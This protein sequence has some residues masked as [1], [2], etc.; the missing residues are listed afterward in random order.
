[1]TIRPPSPRGSKLR[2][3]PLL[4]VG[5]LAGCSSDNDAAPAI[6]IADEPVV[7]PND[8]LPGVVI[9]IDAVRG[10]A[11]GRAEVGDRLAIDFTVKTAAGKPLELS[12]M[13]RGAIMVSGPTFNYQRVIASQ[14]DVLVRARKRALGAFTYEFQ[15][16]IP[17][18]YLPPLNDTDAITEGELTGQPLL[19]GTYTIGL[20]LR[21]DYRV[22]LETYRDPGNA[23]I[24][25]LLGGATTLE[26]REVVTLANCNQCHT[27]LRAHGD[28]RDRITNCLLCHTSGAEDRNTP[29]VAGG[30]PGV[31]I[32]FKV[33]IHKIHAGR[34]LPSVLGVTTNPNGTRKYDAPKRPYQLIGYNDSVADFSTVSFPAW[35]S[36]YTGMPRDQGHTLL[37]PAQQSLEN[38]MRAAPV[39]CA[40]CHG[41]PDGDGALPAPAQSELIW[42]QPTIAACASCH[43]DWVPDHLYTANGQTMPIQR[44]NAACKDC[45]RVSGT[46]LDVVDA[47]RHPLVDPSVVQGVVFDVTSVVDRA[48]NGATNGKFEPGDE[49]EIVF[50]VKNNAGTPIAASALSR[51]ET[52]LSGPTTNPQIVSYQRL[53][54]GYFTGTGPYTFRLPEILW[55]EPIGTSTTG[56]GVNLQIFATARAPHWNITSGAPTSLLRVTGTGP[57]AV[58]TLAAAA[59][60]TQ[61]YID[62][63][64]G[65]G[66]TFAKDNLILIDGGNAGLREFVRIQWVQ[67]NR[68]WFGSQFR[69]NYKPNLQRGH[70]AGATVQ[71][72]TTQAVP[73]GSYLLDA[74][75]G[76]I[77]ETTEFG[78]GEILCTYTS[79]FVVPDVYPGALDDSPV[80]G[81]DWGDWTGLALLSG[82]YTFDMHGARSITVTRF[83][84]NTSYTEGADST[85]V[86]LLFGSATTIVDVARIDPQSC[87]GCHENLQFHGGSRRS[88]EA[89]LQC[90][91]TAGAEQTLLYEDPVNGAPFGTSVEFRYLLHR[92]HDGVFPGMPGGVQDCAKCHG[93]AS[94]AWTLPA[95]RL[96]PAQSVPTRAWRA[97][98][99]S[100]HDSTAEIAH[101][102]ANTS[103]SGAEACAIC[104]GAGENLDVRTVHRIK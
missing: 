62:V 11:P 19:A 97:A 101:I 21:K 32:D 74:T 35:P 41:D 92:L 66:A 17:A 38:T 1:M 48:P 90:H 78:E 49:V 76:V 54:T 27:E 22:G 93:Q 25:F 99:S 67:G 59:S 61:N 24:D 12:T 72:V 100:C 64:P 31:A 30:T 96:H 98:C 94:T 23:T 65:A 51:I 6:G 81:E 95:E 43:D 73:A 50:Q 70:A 44:D 52:I 2:L 42:A 88:V 91:G 5:L 80:N 85:V 16:P 33:M 71:V 46:P 60:R 77:N 102:D 55:H 14:S 53:A 15:L 29:G 45:H 56:G 58:S 39:E 37:T 79:D 20:E 103:P 83:G 86:K 13:A 68:L 9:T 89:C 63:V 82:T 8:V 104:H 47:H 40:K 26:P 18:T 57:G 69:Q 7:G 84:E 36:F 34:H 10:R 28:N 4:L 75:A 87:Y 3:T